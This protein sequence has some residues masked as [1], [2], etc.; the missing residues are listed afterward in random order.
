MTVIAHHEL[1]R[2]GLLKLGGIP[3][4][5][6]RFV[7]I[8]DNPTTTTF[9]ECQTAV[10]VRVG[11]SHPEF[12][13]A[14]CTQVEFNEALDGNRF[15]IEVICEYGSAQ[16]TAD[17]DPEKDP[18]YDI[19]PLLRPDIWVFETQGVAVPALSYYSGSDNSTPLPLTNSANDYFENLLVD[20]AQT[21]VT[22][23]GNRIEFPATTAILL[24]NV[25]NDDTW[26]GAPAHHWKCQG[27]SSTLKFEEIT[28]EG[29]D[30]EPTQQIVRFWEVSTTLMY[31]QGG[32]NLLL[33]DIGFNYLASGQ[34]RRVMT[35]D[36]EN[37]EWIPSP[38]PMGLDGS[39]NQTF[40]APAILNRRIYRTVD[41]SEY[42]SP[43]P[44][45][46]E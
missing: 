36:F 3:E 13:G 4:L 42:F 11:S 16:P 39:G 45:L 6:R 38:V 29:E 37:S 32:W 12:G 43:P 35:F 31:R 22:I 40:G 19:N 8:V 15:H 20:E 41:F 14:K 33:P 2:T 9:D 23:T 1:P 28:V 30:E 21:R 34:K 17:P 46:D 26:L 10:G 25:V 24:T 7:C 18:E 44:D 27:V 5:S